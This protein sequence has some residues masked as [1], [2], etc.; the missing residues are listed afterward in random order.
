MTDVTPTANDPDA[1]VDTNVSASFDQ[2][3]DAGSVNDRTFAVHAMRTG[4]LTVPGVETAGLQVSF[5]PTSDFKAGEIALVTATSGILSSGVPVRPEVWQF[6]AAVSASSPGLFRDTGQSLGSE[7]SSDV[8]LGDLDGD[9]DVDAFETRR[10]G[11]NQVWLNDGS[12]GFT[13]GQAFGD[14]FS[15]E[16]SLGDLDGDGDLDAFVANINEGNRIWLNDG[17]ASFSSNGQAL[18]TS[19]SQGLSLGD[20]DGDGDLDALVANQ[21]GQSGRIWLN[22]GAAGFSSGAGFGAVAGIDAALGDM[23]GDGDLDVVLANKF[24]GGVSVFHNDGA[25]NFTSVASFQGSSNTE[26]I[27]L[28][29]VDGD[30]DLDVFVMNQNRY[31][32]SR[33]WLNDGGSFTQISPYLGFL[34]D[35]EEDLSFGDV[36]GDGDL[37]VFFANNGGNYLWKNDGSGQFSSAG[38][39]GSDST[40]GVD[41]G[42][43]D[44]DGDLDAFFVNS[45]ANRVW[46]NRPSVDLTVTKTDGTAQ[47]TEG[48][49]VGYT[50]VV[51]NQGPSDAIGASITDL[52]PPELTNVSWTAELTAGNTMTPSS[53]SGDI[54]ATADLQSG[55]SI[56]ITVSATVTGT[57]ASRVINNT[58]TVA[59]PEDIDPGNNRATDADL[60]VLPGSAASPGFFRPNGDILGAFRSEGA[61]LGDVDGDGDLDAFVANFNEP[62]A[63]WLNDGGRFTQGG[64]AGA[65]AGTSVRFGDFDGNGTLDAFVGNGLNDADQVWLGDG[66]GNF[67]AGASLGNSNTRGVSLGDVDG[68]GDVDAFTANYGQPNRIWLG[69]GSGN[70]TESGHALGG[71]AS[72]DASLGDVDGDG[73]LDAIVANGAG[74]PNQVWLNDGLGSFRAGAAI[75]SSSS[76]GVRL[77]DL[78]GDGDLDAFVANYAG[79]PNRAWRNDGDGNFTAISGGLGSSFSRAVDLGDV[80]GDGDLDAFV[81]N[82]IDQP[83]RVWLNDSSGNF[84]ISV[85]SLGTSTGTSVTLGDVDGDG[86]LDAFVANGRF[87]VDQANV[88][89][90]NQPAA[91][92]SIT[93]SSGTAQ[94]VEGADVTYTIVVT[95]H[96]PADV[97]DATVTDVFPNELSNVSWTAALAPGSTGI[98]PV[99]GVNDINAAIELTSGSSAIF[100]VTAT[101]IGSLTAGQPAARILTNVAEVTYVDEADG[102]NNRSADGDI[103][104][105]AVSNPKPALLFDSG[106]SLG[107][108]RSY[109]VNLGDLDGDGD[110]DAFVANGRDDAEGDRVWLGDG[111]GHFDDSGQALG[112]HGSLG[113]SLGDVDGDGDLDAFVTTRRLGTPGNRIWLNDGSANFTDSGQGLGDHE[114]YSV[115][116]GDVDGDGDLDAFVANYNEGNR[117]WLGDGSGHF[118]DSGQSLGD[119]STL[120]VALGDVDGDGDLDSVVT[121]YALG[122]PN[123]VW[124]NDGAGRF[125]ESG[126]ALGHEYGFDASLGDLNGDGRLDAF[127]AGRRRPNL[128]WIGDGSGHFTDSGQALGDHASVDSSLGDLDGDGDLDVFVANMTDGGDGADRVWLNDGS[129][130]F[131]GSV[132]ALADHASRSVGLGDVDGDGD[133]DA[134]VA[135]R[136]GQGNRVWLNAFPADL[137]ITK[138]SAVT[139]VVE[140]GPIAYTIVVTNQGPAVV[141]GAAVTDSFDGLTGVSWSVAVSGGGTVD[142]V[143][144]NGALGATVDLAV[145]EHATF[146]VTGTVVGSL[147]ADEAADRILSGAA[148][149]AYAQE[150]NTSDNRAADGDVVVL[151]A[152]STTPGRFEAAQDVAVGVDSRDLSLGD[153]DGDG[154]LDAIT[155]DGGG[156]S[157]LLLSDGGGSFTDS[158]QAFGS[159]DTSGVS[160]GDVDG[161]G[162]LDALFANAGAGAGEGNRLWLGDGSG[163]FTD[164]GQSLGNHA[165][166]AVRLGDVDGDGDL[167]AFVANFSQGNRVWL[168]DGSGLF[169]DSGQSL[170]NRISEDVALGD[171]DGDGD[172]DAFVAND[173]SDLVWFNDGSGSFS[174]GP[175][176]GDHVSV[177]VSLGD[178]DGDGD[179]DGVVAS[180]AGNRLWLNTNGTFSDSGQ[181]LGNADEG[182]EGRA[183]SIALADVDGD[184]DLDVGV[185][186]TSAEGSPSSNRIWRNDGSGAF[187]DSGQMLGGGYTVDGAFGDVDG[188]GDLDAFAVN[189]SGTARVWLNRLSTDLSIAKTAGAVQVTAGDAVTWT[190]VVANLGPSEVVGATVRDTFPSRIENVHLTGIALSGGATSSLTTGPLAFLLDSVDLEVGASVTY[191]LTGTVA[192]MGTPGL[193]ADA[194]LANAATVM[195]PADRIEFDLAD[196]TARDSDVIVLPATG[197]SGVLQDTGQA[198]GTAD[199][200][201]VA[202]GDLNGDGALDAF[203]ANV[204]AN[205]VWFNDGSAN[206]SDSGQ[207]LGS[208]PSRRARLADLDGDGDLDAVVANENQLTRVWRN[209]GSGGF[210]DSGQGLGAGAARDVALGDLDVDGDVDVLVVNR[211]SQSDRVW[212]NDGA[213]SFIDSGQVL[214]SHRGTSARLGDLDGDGD[215]DAFVTNIFEPNRVWLNAGDGNL[216]DSGQV[217]GNSSSWAGRLGDLDD[218]GD[219]DAVVAN[220]GGNRFWR[221]DGSGHFTDSGQLLGNTNPGAEGAPRGVALADLDGDGDLDAGFFVDTA[222]SDGSTVRIWL[223]DGSGDFSDSGQLIGSSRGYGGAFG[224]LD[225][226]GDLDAF[227]ANRGP[228]QAWLNPISADLSITKTSGVTEVPAGGAVTYTIVVSNAG[229]SDAIG[230]TVTDALPA[231]LQNVQLTNIVESGGA[232]TLRTIGSLSGTFVDS[233]DLPASSSITYTIAGTVAPAGTPGLSVDEIVSNPAT[234]QGPVTTID[235]DPSDNAA[236]DSDLVLLAATGGNGLF[237]GGAVLGDHLS[238]GMALGDLDGDGDLDAFETNGSVE[239]NRIWLGDGS[240]GFSDSLQ[241]LGSTDSRAVGLGDVDGDGDLDAVVA[242]YNSGNRLWRN[243]G[244]GGFT[245]VGVDVGS[246]RS[247]GVSLGDVDGDGDPDAVFANSAGEADELWLNDGSGGFALGQTIGSSSSFAIDLGDLDGDG[248]LDAVVASA[249]INVVLVNDGQGRFNDSGQA[250]GDHA[251]FDV[252]LGDLDGDGA[253]DAFTA[254]GGGNR[255]WIN[256]AGGN[257]ADGGQ[258]LG[259]HSSR[260]AAL[261]D[262]DGDG[263]LDAFVANAAGE[264]GRVWLND[265]SGGFSAGAAALGDHGSEAVALGDL[266]GDGDLDAIVANLGFPSQGSRVW[267]NASADLSITKTSGVVQ[268]AE[269]NAIT[270]TIVVTNAGPD[271]VVGAT[272]T[273]VIPSRLES[274]DLSTIM[275]SGGAVSSL[276]TGPIAGA[277]ADTVDLPA[278]ASVTYTVTATVTLVSTPSQPVEAIVTNPAT[279][280]GPANPPDPDSSNNAAHDSD[281]IVQAPAGGRGVFTNTGQE[282]ADH[283]STGVSLGDLDG[284]G[285]LD[286]FVV[287]TNGAPNRV[288]R[289]DGS[290]NFVDS[291]QEVGALQSTDV[292]LADLDGD[293]HLDAFVTNR[294]EPNRVWLNN[295]FGGF[296]ASTDLSGS[297]ASTAVQLGDLDGDGDVDA[298]VTNFGEP[299]RIWRNDGDGNFA[300][301]GQTLVSNSNDVA[302]GDADGDGDLDAFVANGFQGNRVWLNDAGIF[303]DS[304]QSLGNHAS[305]KVSLGDVDGDGDL[306]AVVANYEHGNR[307]WLGDG[308]G[309]FA[310]SGQVLGNA[311]GTGSGA[312]QAVDLADLNGDGH[313]DIGFFVDTGET[314]SIGPNRV[315]LNDGSG[316]FTDNGQRLGVAMSFDGAFGDLDGDGDLDAFV[317]NDGANEVW[318]GAKSADLSITKSSGVTQVT[319]GGAITYTIAVSNAGPDEAIGAMVRDTLPAGIGNVMLTAIVPGAGASSSLAVGPLAGAL[320]DTVDLP[321]GG[322][323]I[324]TVTATVDAPGTPNGATEQILTN[325]ATVVVPANLVDQDSSDNTSQDSDVVVPAGPGGSGVLDDGGAIATGAYG[326]DVSL[327]DLDGDGDLDAFF[328]NFGGASQVWINDGS[329]VLA[330][331]GQSLGTVDSRGVSLGDLDGDGDLDAFVAVYSEANRIWRNDGSGNF[332]DSG[333]SLGVHRSAAAALGDLDADGDLDA[334]VANGG[335]LHAQANDVWLNDGS[336]NFTDSGQQLANNTTRDVSLGDLDGDGD[337]DAFTVN[338]GGQ[339]NRVWMGDGR[340]GFTDSGQFVG[341]LPG[342]GVS[343][344]DLDGDGDLDAFLANGGENEVWFND[345]GG[346]FVDSGQNLSLQTSSDVSVG[347]VDGDGDLDAFVSSGFF[348]GEVNRLWLGDG[349]G[350]F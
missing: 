7:I 8:S 76:F 106:Q 269:G 26:A 311:S 159:N 72:R 322:S 295:G 141:T 143:N 146:S 260:G 291:G 181:I 149:V 184:G 195:A 309:G 41:L 344:N 223:N 66:S 31:R 237:V 120:G 298:F 268:V 301:A 134:F 343:L 131:A 39:Y 227:V 61:A 3:V 253:L 259:D 36:D 241:S 292:Q 258:P 231:R 238:V 20:V 306:D 242:N 59:H 10:T 281:G 239:G 53:G 81:A 245:D 325:A 135:S 73:D 315:W 123:R 103:I 155:V 6:R 12:A 251:S 233:V 220:D 279:V 93:K 49:L 101:L 28:G 174:A 142:P 27:E 247:R 154:D 230:A 124:L 334:F 294:S 38:R 150:T 15:E 158:G 133:L 254:N 345:G 225:H 77:G 30:G 226:D 271:A 215:L 71:S 98:L 302:L 314:S 266:D 33:V 75:G 348:G 212:L 110:L 312:A 265:A 207:A 332:T 244:S 50:I 296:P 4:Q 214:G 280:T 203:V 277:L 339:G 229:P 1:P 70:F 333:Q 321:V 175:D 338:S 121:N 330:D 145:G 201:G 167:D 52:F 88:V 125:S 222:E 179:L 318:R 2:N 83:N 91:D 170:G 100:T 74:Q 234:I 160:L 206:L 115:S 252:R 290:G 341:M 13:T 270:Y 211:A 217:L 108:H 151:V 17:N 165:S 186:V 329:A 54:I 147:T 193:P 118:D 99:G 32:T 42:D 166:L 177:A 178:V 342:F 63:I 18:G 96:G 56:Q 283:R 274:V 213:G 171:V 84:T 320:A 328:A 192:P 162:A 144:G 331:S 64:A 58:V 182:V 218:D 80:D 176:V 136:L 264:P 287:N 349:S 278:G 303:S 194:V 172:L 79:Q 196:N 152:S 255:V 183:R 92:L 267:L 163:N 130:N 47:V 14:H 326:E 336:G 198:L 275:E 173:V 139:Q 82:G 46:L 97:F 187:A 308:A 37:D 188:D 16:V 335:I 104:F 250:L 132:Q 228:N 248:D 122:D 22:D 85:S 117:V 273:D 60:I 310:D 114:S 69:D 243:D 40:R 89:W 105:P 286:A 19:S 317:V 288:W 256:D 161:D 94:V 323:I 180:Q 305:E 200:Y 107:D 350:N 307:L 111:S 190:I 232:F 45:G 337:L 11:P 263:D 235:L 257:F 126:Q 43:L 327:G 129:G 313:L 113:A 156:S 140:G 90:L 34:T 112:V 197:G 340:G 289:N 319:E 21:N 216:V 148:R 282:L 29:D 9:G 285:D 109:G 57:S 210:T 119:H 199:S 261:G 68:D 300:D 62:D 67:S 102:S 284:D 169:A 221:N 219:L 116:L 236:H 191:T 23:D 205:R 262:V 347:D 153:V 297:H 224:D 209:D 208:H 240:G 299:N 272:V 5:N 185:F 316:R 276:A 78:D 44:G 95:N 293:G 137:S 127:I 246:G 55:A 87:V 249:G 324:Y 304:G 164:S 25:G 346:V 204:G 157:R 24:F 189:D 168:G 65:G 51:T 128:V 86:D 138:S 48:T 202:L 35:G